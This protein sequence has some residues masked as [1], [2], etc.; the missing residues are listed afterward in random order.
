MAASYEKRLLLV[1]SNIEMKA[2]ATTTQDTKHQCSIIVKISS[3]NDGEYE[4][5]WQHLTHNGRPNHTNKHTYSRS[6]TIT[7]KLTT[8]Y[9]LN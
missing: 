6:P 5:C 2:G 4:N 9:K 8:L 3:G 7:Y 1:P